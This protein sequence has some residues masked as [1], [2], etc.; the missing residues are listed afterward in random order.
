MTKMGVFKRGAD[1]ITVDKTGCYFLGLFKTSLEQGNR[2][3][4]RTEKRAEM[5]KR[6][7]SV[8]GEP[9]AVGED[10]CFNFPPVFAFVFRSFNSLEGI[11]KGLYPKYDSTMIA[12]PYLK[13]LIDL[14]DGSTTKADIKSFQKRVGW[15]PQDIKVEITQPWKTA[16]I[17]KTL[18]RMETSEI[19][20]RVRVL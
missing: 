6:L 10:E 14:R 20:L 11:G 15:K 17:E 9:L 13:K 7:V 19:R 5:S 1:R 16:Y 3:K 12:G 18:R 8:S 2:K 4:D